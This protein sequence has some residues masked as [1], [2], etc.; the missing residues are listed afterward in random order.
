MNKSKTAALLML[1]SLSLMVTAACSKHKDPTLPNREKDGALQSALDELTRL[2]AYTATGLNYSEYSDRLLTAESN[3]EVAFKRTSDEAAKA[4][5]RKAISYYIAARKEWGD[6]IDSKSDEF[7][8]IYEMELQKDWVRGRFFAGQA[9]EYAFAD[10]FRR[11]QIEQ[12]SEPAEKEMEEAFNPSHGETKSTPR[13]STAPFFAVLTIDSSVFTKDHREI[14]LPAGT[15]LKAVGRD[16][17]SIV[18]TLG[19]DSETYSLPDGLFKEE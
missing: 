10:V 13:P 6:S 14:K 4:K 1:V 7:K 9:E 18:F 3:I 11:Q 15:R 19:N 17:R 8:A 2:Q 12:E 5:I 16:G